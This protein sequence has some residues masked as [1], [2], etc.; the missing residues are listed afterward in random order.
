[1]WDRIQTP[2]TVNTLPYAG[3]QVRKEHDEDKRPSELSRHAHEHDSF[4]NPLGNEGSELRPAAKAC[5]TAFASR[6]GL[7]AE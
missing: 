6:K 2:Y 5:A 3:S 4:F 1:M 7:Y